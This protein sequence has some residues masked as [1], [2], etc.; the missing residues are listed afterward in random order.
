MG[1]NWCEIENKYSV[2]KKSVRIERC[3]GIAKR[4]IIYPAKNLFPMVTQMG[5]FMNDFTAFNS[6]SGARNNHDDAPDSVCSFADEVIDNS[7]SMSEV[8]P[9]YR[10]F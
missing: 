10:P 8:I 5:K 7:M 2:E 6:G 4:K 3:K 1:V 9:I